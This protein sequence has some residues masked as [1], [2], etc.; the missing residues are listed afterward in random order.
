VAQRQG[1]GDAVGEPA[2]AF[3]R[4]F[5]RT[6]GWVVAGLALIAACLMMVI[7]SLDG[8][9][10]PLAVAYLLLGALGLA[11]FTAGVL[12]LVWQLFQRRPIV[13]IGPWGVLDRRLSS[14]SIP[15]LTV[16][17]VRVTGV[18]RQRF[19]TLDL[20]PGAERAALSSRSARILLRVNRRTGYPGVHIGT[21]GLRCRVENLA[22]AVQQARRDPG[23]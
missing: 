13:L 23:S 9:P 8:L 22:E 4:S 5:W 10:H 16:A 6:L 3:H 20:F 11:L 17:S 12:R 2:T 14:R 21:V 7:S 1:R 18:G 19:L 15:W